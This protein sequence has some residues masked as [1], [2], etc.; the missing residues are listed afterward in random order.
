MVDIGVSLDGL[1]HLVRIF[2][3]IY[4]KQ[5]MRYMKLKDTTAS[6]SVHSIVVEKKSRTYFSIV[7][8]VFDL[9]ALA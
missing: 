1:Y 3:C 4:T 2:A 5:N 7:M 8:F 9:D 6:K